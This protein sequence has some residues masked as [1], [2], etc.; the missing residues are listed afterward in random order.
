M[1][2]NLLFLFLAAFGFYVLLRKVKTK[3][4]FILFPFS[5]LFS[6]LVAAI[7]S[8]TLSPVFHPRNLQII[9][10]NFL[11]LSALA[12][13]WLCQRKYYVFVLIALF[14]VLINFNLTL[15]LFSKDDGRL[16]LSFYPWKQIKSEMEAKGVKSVEFRSGPKLPQKFIFGLKY[17][18]EGKETLG[19]KNIPYK[20]LTINS[21]PTI[22]CSPDF[23]SYLEL[24]ECF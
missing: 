23:N 8:I 15:Q 14:I 20:E 3:S 16:M 7:I 21:H 12:L 6:S 4:G 22:D 19:S 10:I 11:F 18:L 5:A 1:I 9:A 2:F 17:T 24:Y 13:W